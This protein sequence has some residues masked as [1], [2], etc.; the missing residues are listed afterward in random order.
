MG[1]MALCL[2]FYPLPMVVI[3]SSLFSLSQYNPTQLSGGISD[4]IFPENNTTAFAADPDRILKSTN[5]GLLWSAILIDPGSFYN[6]LLPVDNNTVFALSTAY[7]TNKLIKTN[8]GGASWQTVTVP[9]LNTGKI[10]AA[11]FLTANT[12]WLSMYDNN[13]GYYFYKTTDGGSSWVLINNLQA[14]PF[15]CFKMHFTDINTGYAL[16]GQNTV[17]KT[18]NSGVTW[19]PLPRDNNY[20]YLGYNHN[21]LQCFSVSQLWAGGGHGFLEMS[22]NAGGATLPKAYFN[23]DTTGTGTTNIVNLVNFSRT[24]YTYKWFVNNVQVSTSYNASYTHTVNKLSDTV[25]LVVSNGVSTDTLEK[26]P[27]IFST[28]NCNGLC[29]FICY[30]LHYDSNIRYQFRWGHISKLWWR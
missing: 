19:E 24:G 29:P 15:S 14:T 11:Y 27:A 18:L 22:T 5:Q 20:V 28:G 16:S 17:Y 2:L 3:L 12:G 9:P 30:R 26:I 7:A 4:M 25:K 23:I 21:D 8:N 1:I 10:T 13:N 6:Q